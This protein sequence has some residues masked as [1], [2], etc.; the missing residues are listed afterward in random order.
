MFFFRGHEI[1]NINVYHEIYIMYI[2]IYI[3]THHIYIVCYISYIYIKYNIINIT[4]LIHS[5]FH[6]YIVFY[7]IHT[8]IYI[9]Y[10]YL[11]YIY[12]YRWKNSSSTSLENQV[13]LCWGHGDA[14]PSSRGAVG[15]GQWTTVDQRIGEA[16]QTQ[17]VSAPR[18][19]EPWLSQA[20]LCEEIEPLVLGCF[21]C[22]YVYIY[23]DVFSSTEN[24]VYLYLSQMIW[25]CKWYM[26]L[27]WLVIETE[28]K[29]NN[30]PLGMARDWMV[31]IWPSK[32]VVM[33]SLSWKSWYITS[34]HVLKNHWLANE[35]ILSFCKCQALK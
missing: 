17:V 33:M 35:Y 14:Q 28:K 3:Y 34:T 12:T 11:S 4:C 16:D 6:I 13:T 15:Q 26:R 22:V 25:E 27:G 7:I 30:R 18:T 8:Y 32:R 31:M 19:S 24:E 21:I 10:I 2:Y 5:I 20:F 29:Q 1:T 9:S 23:I